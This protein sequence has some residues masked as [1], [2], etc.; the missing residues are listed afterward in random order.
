MN[1]LVG[2]DFL[3]KDRQDRYSLTPE[4]PPFSSALSPRSKA[5]Y[6]V[7]SASS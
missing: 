6:F 4:T 3:A 1:A 7:M 5:D 2:L